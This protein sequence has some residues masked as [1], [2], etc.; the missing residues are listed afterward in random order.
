MR[1]AIAIG[2]IVARL[3][4]GY[5]VRPAIR[6][7]SYTFS[8]APTQ[9]VM[10]DLRPVAPHRPSEPPRSQVDPDRYPILEDYAAA[11]LKEKL[12]EIPHN[13]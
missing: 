11:L 3:A 2:Q 1:W 13:Q 6:N 7:D 4:E 9:K 10:L 12:A 5:S 8:I